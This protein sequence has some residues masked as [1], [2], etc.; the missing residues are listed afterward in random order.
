VADTSPAPS[1]APVELAE[2]TTPAETSTAPPPATTLPAES[3]PA[4]RNPPGGAS[5]VAA[6]PSATQ[7]TATVGTTP[8]APPAA[9]VAP[10]A[11]TSGDFGYLD[12]LPPEGPDGRT[13]GEDAARKYR[14]E[15]GAYT[16]RRFAARPRVPRGV[17]L[18]ERPAVATLLYVHSAQEAYHRRN[19]RY[20]SARELHDSKLLVLDV[21]VDAS[22][23]RRARYAFS[24]AVEADGYRAEAQPQAPGGRAFLVDDSGFVRFR[25]E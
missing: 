6:R 14:G 1:A 7:G 3:R 24:V 11:A 20:A 2:A 13:L 15:G 23:F 17:T 12:E 4:V 8:P 10:S 25:D 18:P 22:G 21:P 9:P 16:N 5:G 19:G